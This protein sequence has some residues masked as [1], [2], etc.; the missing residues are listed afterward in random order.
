VTT[1]SNGVRVGLLWRAEWDPVQQGAP[2][3]ESCRLHGMFAALRDLGVEAEPVV[4]S[5]DDVDA[6][7]EQLLGL[8]GVLVWVNPIEQGLD[9]S[10]LDA[11]LRDVSDAGRWVSAHP[12]VILRMATKQV[13]V[14]TASMSW[15]VETRLY[16]THDQLRAELP[17]RLAARE[18][19]VLKQHR[20]MGGDG[21]WKVELEGRGEIVRVQHASGDGLPEALPIDAFLERCAGYFAGGGLMVEQPLPEGM[22]RVYLCHDRVVGFAHQY[23]R[24]LLPPGSSPPPGKVFELATS[25]PYRVLRDRMETQWVPELQRLLGL[26]THSLPVIWDADFL[27]GPKTASGEDTYVL[28]EINASSTFAFPEHAMPTVARAA[29]DRI[30]RGRELRGRDRDGD[31]GPSARPSSSASSSR[32]RA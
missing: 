22:I 28:C 4:Y 2:V 25:P 23:P 13:L 11:L 26:D 1:A 30:S 5:D 7:R 21:V 14:D 27:F 18:P 9:R 15:S 16:A 19:L 32:R 31:G 20:G 8:D 24:G 6:V 10:R 3:A 29:L 12:D 17:G